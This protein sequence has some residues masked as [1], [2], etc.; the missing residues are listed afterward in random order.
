M[1]IPKFEHISFDINNLHKFENL[2]CFD[3]AIKNIEIITEKNSFTL[4]LDKWIYLDESWFIKTF[5]FT[6]NFDLED[7]KWVKKIVIPIFLQERFNKDMKNSRILKI[8]ESKEAIKSTYNV[9]MNTYE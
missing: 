1:H 4:D 6:I 2:V 7:F 5:W 8:Q 3:N 9:I